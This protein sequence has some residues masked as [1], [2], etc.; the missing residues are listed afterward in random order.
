MLN[1]WWSIDLFPDF[2]EGGT[3]IL[4]EPLTFDAC[5][6]ENKKKTTCSPF[7]LIRHTR[8][9]KHSESQAN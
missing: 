8:R 2:L 6:L 3:I 1:I 9:L 4:F 5:M 7:D